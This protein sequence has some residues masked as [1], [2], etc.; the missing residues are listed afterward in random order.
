[1]EI[2]LSSEPLVDL[3]MICTWSFAPRLMYPI[4][5]IAFFRVG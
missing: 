1:M 5:A 3:F 2:L 4:A